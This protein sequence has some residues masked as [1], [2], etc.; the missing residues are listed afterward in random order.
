[1][2]VGLPALARGEP[3]LHPQL[4][5]ARRAAENLEIVGEL[6]DQR[7]AETEPAV[8]ATR[9]Q[10]GAVVAD[11]QPELA[12]HVGRAQLDRPAAPALVGMEHGV[13]DRLGRGQ[14]DR[15]QAVAVG[16]DRDRELRQR[17]A[18][19]GDRIWDRRIRV[20]EPMICV[21]HPDPVDTRLGEKNTSQ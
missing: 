11:Q 18:G 5:A 7:E 15:L 12:V 13:G 20:A 2:A 6:R 9:P 21:K 8:R 10:A 4:G 17:V 14:P 3:E 19:L 16:A 1:M